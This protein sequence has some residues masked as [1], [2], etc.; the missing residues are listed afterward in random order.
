MTIA[1]GDTLPNEHLLRIGKDGPEVVSVADLTAGRLV[2]LF[3]VP[4]AFTP[5]CHQHHVPSF[6]RTSQ[7]LALKGVHDIV[8]IAVNDPFVVHA[9]GEA[10]GARAVGIEM[11]ADP[12]GT[13]TKA[14][15]LAFDFP[16]AGLWGR[17]K[18]YAMLVEDG[19]VR[20]FHL[21]ETPGVC[22]LTTGEA[23]LAAA[24]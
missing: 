19:V 14:L 10:T 13:F 1:V 15:G 3:A 24:G 9:W 6:V 4:G 12:A 23:L 21:E 18:R 16:Q 22:E 8:C 17:S 7:Q 5:T 11:M 2:A 20:V